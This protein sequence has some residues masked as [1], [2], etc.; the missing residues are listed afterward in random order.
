MKHLLVYLLKIA[1][2]ILIV[3]LL[4]IELITIL[5]L[6]IGSLIWLFKLWEDEDS[7]KKP[8]FYTQLKWQIRNFNKVWISL[9]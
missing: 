4:V 3:I 9:N 6:N 7:S 5:I 8:M 2:I 1:A